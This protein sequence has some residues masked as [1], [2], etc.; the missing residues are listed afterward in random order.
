MQ[1]AGLSLTGILQWREFSKSFSNHRQEFGIIYGFLQ[2]SGRSRLNSPVLV[3]SSIAS[4]D[5]DDR[6]HSERENLFESFHHL[7]TIA[8]NQTEVEDN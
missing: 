6:D 4:G 3:R 1:P 7:E 8:S 5:D 2:I